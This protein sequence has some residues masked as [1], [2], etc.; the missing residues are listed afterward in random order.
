M[1][2]SKKQILQITQTVEYI[3]NLKINDAGDEVCYFFLE[4]KI[5]IIAN[6]ALVDILLIFFNQG[7]ELSILIN[8]EAQVYTLPITG[9][10][11]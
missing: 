7:T 1:N 10:L 5:I 3:E 8:S 4:C 9:E 11:T 6:S 2:L